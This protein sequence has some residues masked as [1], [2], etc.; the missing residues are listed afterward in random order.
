MLERRRQMGQPINSALLPPP[1]ALPPM[2]PMDMSAVQA[3]QQ[4]GGMQPDLGPLMRAL[5]QRLAD[6]AQMGKR[7]KQVD[8]P[9][10]KP[11]FDDRMNASQGSAYA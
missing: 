2:Q 10:R 4:A 8:A 7:S 11:T 3:P 9:V 6:N 5:G 1:P